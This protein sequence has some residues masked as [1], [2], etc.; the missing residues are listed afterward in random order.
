MGLSN[1]RAHV[2]RIAPLLFSS[3]KRPICAE[4]FAEQG[5]NTVTPP[6]AVNIGAGDL[7]QV[8]TVAAV[9]GEKMVNLGFRGVNICRVLN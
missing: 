3:S 6:M 2:S 5:W 8:E 9:K 4:V 1:T 7:D